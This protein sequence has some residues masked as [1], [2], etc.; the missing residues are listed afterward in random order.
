MLVTDILLEENYHSH[1][2]QKKEAIETK[3]GW[4]NHLGHGSHM[5]KAYSRTVMQVHTDTDSRSSAPIWEET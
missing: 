5:Q 4:N 3:L 2:N 1:Y